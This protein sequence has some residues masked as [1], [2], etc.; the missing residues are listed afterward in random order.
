MNS[1]APAPASY[2]ESFQ[3]IA[4][5]HFVLRGRRCLGQEKRHQRRGVMVISME[6]DRVVVDFRA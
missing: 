6:N 5:Q 4:K 2:M 1:T 3:Q